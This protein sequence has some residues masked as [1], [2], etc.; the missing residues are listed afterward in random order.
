MHPFW[1]MDRKDKLMKGESLKTAGEIKTYL[2]KAKD[3]ILLEGN[4]SILT[5][6]L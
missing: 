1:A 5:H 4:A 2:C 3:K 6:Y